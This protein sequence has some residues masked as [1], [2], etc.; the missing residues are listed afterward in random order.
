MI[1]RTD[2]SANTIIAL[3]EENDRLRRQLDSIERYQA[4]SAFLRSIL[5]ASADCIKVL[6]L[7]G[8][9]AYMNEGGQ[10]LMEVSDFNEIK[11]C[12]WPN[13]WEGEGHEE[14]KRALR[15]A[16]DGQMGRFQ[17]D[18]KTF[19]GTAK[20]WDV[21]VTPIFDEAGQPRRILSVSRDITQAKL[22]ELAVA[23][24]E[25]NYRNL[26]NAIAIGFCVVEVRCDDQGAPA[27]YRF[28]Q[29]NKAFGEITGL[30]DIT[31]H[32]M[33]DLAP[34]QESTW[35]ERYAEMVATGKA[36]HFEHRARSLNDRHFD[37]Y[38]YPLGPQAPH[39]VAVLFSDITARKHRDAQR[40]AL[41]E[42]STRLHDFDSAAD[43]AY[44]A[45]EIT[46]RTLGVSRV[47]YGVIQP[48]GQTLI[49]E[50]DWTA[51]GIP[52]GAGLHFLNSYGEA[53]T[54]LDEGKAIVVSDIAVDP[55]TQ[56]G[57]AAFAEA[58][59][60]ALVN[61]PLFDEGRLEAVLF[62]NS[63]RPRVWSEDELNFISDVAKLAQGTLERRRSKRKL[64]QLATSLEGQV[65]ERARDRDRLWRLSG[66]LMLVAD[67]QGGIVRSN[68]AW[69][70]I[71]GW[72]P[73]ELI[74]MNLFDLIHPEDLAHTQQGASDINHRS[75][76]L[77]HFE[78]RYRCKNGDYRW[79]SWTAQA[80]DGF[81]VG[82]GRDITDDKEQALALA[83]AEDA[84][85]QSQKMEAVGQ[86]TG[87]LAHDFNNLL[88]AINGAM[89]LLRMR[90]NQGRLKDLDRYIGAALGASSKAAALTHR[91]LAF[92]R[93]QALDPRSTDVNALIADM[94]DLISRTVGPQNEIVVI[95]EPELWRARIDPPQL[96]NVL[97]NLCINA[98]DA[99][100]DGGRITIQTANHHFEDPAAE[101]LDL[102]PG[103][104]L[105]LCVIDTGS[106]IPPEHLARIFD[107]FFTTKPIGEGTGLGLSMI[108]GFAK[109]SGG[110]V[111]VESTSDEGTTLCLY[112]PRCNE[113][114]LASDCISEASTAEMKGRGEVVLVVEDE[115]VLRMLA[116]EMLGDMGYTTLEASESSG[117]LEIL[118]SDVRIDLLITDV[119]LPGRMNG[120]QLAAIGREARPGLKVLFITGY[121]DSAFQDEGQLAADM[122]V[123]AKPFSVDAFAARID[124]LLGN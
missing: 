85:R 115:P 81:I 61:T 95:A 38:A 6:D 37:L 107:P 118:E 112:M 101:N 7:E 55:R 41:I 44:L 80:A 32:W 90:L 71:L 1:I 56:R 106:G 72:L 87:G 116:T 46:G 19:Q 67:S 82:V 18:A 51:P 58:A 10:A 54:G 52:S 86:L 16:R 119:G 121:A 8:R 102:E 14:A 20:W 88:A 48:G 59:V 22:N 21:Q 35:A 120:R 39:Q 42:L 76:R 34:D 111:R 64:R 15:A 84:L 100:P 25:A 57:A 49:I 23:E 103:D 92:S 9:L 114:D 65:A 91:L 108:Y 28:L 45:A 50:R 26:Y 123:L 73:E 110:L 94:T 109:Q 79:I 62:V 78:N 124:K 33:G 30:T 68:P 2:T 97:L 122:E 5:A 75:A 13:F 36:V 11:G 40:A 47:G 66:D 99:M 27:D 63:D 29:V 96:E 98:R 74:G 113:H 117:G 69:T 53:L 43:I 70:E 93:R 104:Y 24:Q 4:D 12:P 77:T 60:A 105:S 31:G 83:T 3:T 89:E 17:G